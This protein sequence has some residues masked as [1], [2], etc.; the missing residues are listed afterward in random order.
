M[1][2][3]E[4]P[5]PSDLAEEFTTQLRDANQAF[6]DETSTRMQR[7]EEKYGPLKFLGTDTLE[8]AMFEVVDLANYTRMTYVKLYLLQQSI[9]KLVSKHPVANVEGFVSLKEMMGK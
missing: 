2:E 8:E 4:Q 7:G 5:T 1:P 3:S 9:Q 6:W